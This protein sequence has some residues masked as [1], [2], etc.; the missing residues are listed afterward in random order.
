MKRTLLL[1]LI[2]I[3]AAGFGQKTLYIGL[4]G[5][6]GASG[7]INQNTYGM[8]EMDYDI[9]ASYGYNLNI[10]YNFTKHLGIKLELGY[11]RLGQKYSDVINFQDVTR[12]IKEGYFMVPVLFKY[13]TAG[14][15]VRFYLLAGPQMAFLMSG[16]QEYMVNGVQFDTVLTNPVTGETFNAGEPDIKDRLS[17]MDVMGRIDLGVD[18]TLVKNLFL[19][20]GMTMSYGLLDLNAEDY[21]IEDVTGNYNPSHNF[22]GGLNLG[23]S[24]CI[25][26]K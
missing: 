12:Q 7:V 23:L 2:L 3:S 19:T 26:F 16:E 25:P 22:Y 11:A 9:P 18:I 17:S 15:V 21:R 20:V 8:A 24:Y 14:K 1:A 10:G 4:G 5:Y 6:Y 13:N